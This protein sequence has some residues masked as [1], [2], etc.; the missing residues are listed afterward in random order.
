[1]H[2]FFN[3]SMG[4]ASTNGNGASVAV[5]NRRHEFLFFV[6]D[7]DSSPLRYDWLFLFFF[8]FSSRSIGDGTDRH[9]MSI[10][11]NVWGSKALPL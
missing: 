11:H 1:M 5:D 2:F 8:F 10:P 4:R 6:G 7:R 3:V 9:I